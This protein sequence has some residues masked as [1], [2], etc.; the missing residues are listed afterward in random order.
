ME[1][2][3]SVLKAKGLDIGYSTKKTSLTVAQNITFEATPGKLICLLGKNGIGKSTLLKTI[4]KTL[5][6]LSGEICVGD[7]KLAQLSQLELAKHL[8][9]V[10]TD[11]LP[12][13]EFTAYEIIALGRQPYTNWLG[14]LTSEDKKIIDNA[15]ATFNLKNVV[16]K[17]HY[18]LSD[19]QLQKVMIARAYAQET[20]TIILDEPTSHLDFHHAISVFQTL[21]ELSKNSEKTI[22]ISTH[23]INTAL[24][25]ADELWLMTPEGFVTGSPDELTK[26]NALKSLFPENRVIFHKE[27]QQ[28]I[29]KN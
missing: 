26:N 22:L 1:F 18:E 6:I 25:L 16:S 27:L 17:K 2:T 5:P 3:K 7:R 28:F 9:Y 4:A 14:R 23:D 24:Q 21:K 12:E 11:P 13:S 20:P 15:I 10:F 29:V 19:G 8:S